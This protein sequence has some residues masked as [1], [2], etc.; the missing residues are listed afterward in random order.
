MPICR[1]SDPPFVL[2]LARDLSTEINAGQILKSDKKFR[3][4]AFFRKVN[5]NVFNF[6]TVKNGLFSLPPKILKKF[7]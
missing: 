6:S 3:Q 2:F 7:F 4:S 1:P 5:F